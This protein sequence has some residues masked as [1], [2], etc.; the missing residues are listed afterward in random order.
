MRLLGVLFRFLPVFSKEALIYSHFV[1]A[2]QR[3]RQRP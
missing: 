1:I 2:V 3:A